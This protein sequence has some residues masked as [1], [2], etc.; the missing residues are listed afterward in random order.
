MSRIVR[1]GHL[2]WTHD[3]NECG[4]Y[5]E[6]LLYGVDYASAVTHMMLSANITHS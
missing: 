5:R 3:R 4:P 2:S 1:F 6:H